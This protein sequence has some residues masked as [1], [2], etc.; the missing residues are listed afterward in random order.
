VIVLTG[1]IWQWRNERSLS[2]TVS[3]TTSVATGPTVP[4]PPIQGSNVTTH[5]TLQF[6]QDRMLPVATALE[7]IWRWYAL[8]NIVVVIGKDGKSNEII[9]WTVFLTLDRPVNPQQVL[10]TSLSS[11]PR[12]EVKDR[13]SR[14]VVVAFVGDLTDIAVDIRVVGSV[15][16]APMVAAPPIAPTHYTERDIRELL[17]A[18]AKAQELDRDKISQTIFQIQTTAANWVGIYRNQNLVA[19]LKELRTRLQTD[20]WDPIDELVYDNH[21]KDS[22]YI[23]QMR[24]AFAL[25]DEAA[26]GELTRSFQPAID[27]IG[28]LPPNPPEETLQLVSPQFAELLKQANVAYQWY[29]K[30]HDRIPQMMQSLRTNG[31]TGYEKK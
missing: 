30:L 12:Y 19:K 26:K 1:V 24:A 7:N 16:P 2:T 31:V 20:V 6:G 3:G 21:D 25:D 5:L 4:P 13:D 8:A 11:L 14:S 10:V 28:K 27:A 22:L 17:D 29:I 23:Q 9:T 18:L 15:V